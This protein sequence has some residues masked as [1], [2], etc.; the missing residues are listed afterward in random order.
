MSLA[1]TAFELEIPLR[2]LF[3][4]PTVAGLAVQIG[5]LKAKEGSE[6]EM[7]RLLADLEWVSDDEEARTP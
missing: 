3:E 6:E 7:R 4:N 2:M 5:P 1:R